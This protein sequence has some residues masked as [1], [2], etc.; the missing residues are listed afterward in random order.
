[1]KL[2]QGQMWKKGDDY[3]RIIHWERLAIE[4]KLMHGAPG[5]K[6]TVHRVP[7]KEF[8]RMLKGAELMPDAKPEPEEEPLTPPMPVPQPRE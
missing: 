1:M 3:L 7:K 4:Y 5:G 8:C 6:G 2:H